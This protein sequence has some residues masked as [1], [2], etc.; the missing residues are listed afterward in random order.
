MNWD[1]EQKLESMT[2]IGMEVRLIDR[3]TDRETFSGVVEDEVAIVVEDAKHVIQ[4][5]RLADDTRRDGDEYGYRT[6]TFFVDRHTGR[7]KWAQYSQAVTETE[8]Q[9]LLAL[10]K[11]KGWA[12]PVGRDPR[13]RHGSH[14]AT[15]AASACRALPQSLNRAAKHVRIGLH[16]VRREPGIE[17]AL[18]ITAPA[19]RE[20][21]RRD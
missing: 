18:T 12:G 6:G 21:D 4:R 8:L 16:H 17:D 9:E 5:I 10:A 7:I 20:G 19:P 2:R 3:Q 1:D 15:R 13:R 11:K 14:S